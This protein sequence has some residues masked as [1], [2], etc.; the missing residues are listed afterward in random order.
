MERLDKD[1]ALKAKIVFVSLAA[2]VAI[3]LIWSVA[4][5]ARAKSERNAARQE[6][7]AVRQDNA[8]LEQ[9]VSDLNSEN[10]AL[11]KKVRQFEAKA[12]AR[13]K[14]AAAKKKSTSRKTTRKRR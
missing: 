10:H 13:P 4:T 1:E 7:E 8:K 6:L 11:K 5:A 14:T 9:M 3:L 2:L 12:K